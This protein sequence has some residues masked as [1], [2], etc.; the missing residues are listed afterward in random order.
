MSAFKYCIKEIK[1][2]QQLSKKG[3]EEEKKVAVNI[4]R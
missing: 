3:A 4:I 2:L 1:D